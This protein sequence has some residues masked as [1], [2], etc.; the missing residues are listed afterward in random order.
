MTEEEFGRFVKKVIMLVIVA[1]LILI[2]IGFIVFN[3]AGVKKSVFASQ[4]DADNYKKKVQTIHSRELK[5]KEDEELKKEK[6]SLENKEEKQEKEKT[7]E[8][9]PVEEQP[10]ET[11]A[12]E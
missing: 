8:E 5:E 7:A 1:V 2:V 10:A 12:E 11:P 4:L 3:K 6:E 9:A